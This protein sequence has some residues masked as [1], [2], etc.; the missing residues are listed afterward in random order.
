MSEG[1]GTPPPADQGPWF[2]G[3]DTETVAYIQNRGLDKMTPKDAALAA[4][5]SHRSA[6]SQLGWGTDKLLKLPK[7]ANDTATRD[8]LYNKLGRPET[9][10]KY[11]FSGIE[12]DPEFQKFAAP[13]YHKLGLTQAQVSDLL[14]ETAGRV[15]AET[16]NEEKARTAAHAVE[17]QELLKNWG[18]NTDAN[19]VV[20]QHAYSKLGFNEAQIKAIESQIGFAQTMSMFHNLGTKL[21]EDAFVGGGGAASVTSKDQAM[22]RLSELKKDNSY[23]KRYM[24]GDIN[25]RKEMTDLHTLAYAT[26]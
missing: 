19:L 4:I 18:G 9:A 5:K 13:L 12:L 2:G 11:D 17:K 16:A 8:A 7:D 3:V 22:A 25:V 24:D 20:A 1:T 6:E 23:M 26:E 15:A 14:K 21:G 10:D